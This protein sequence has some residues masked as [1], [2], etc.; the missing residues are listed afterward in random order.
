M[1]WGA[2]QI[3]QIKRFVSKRGFRE[4]DL[5]LEMVDHLACKMEELWVDQPH[6]TFEEVLNKAHLSFGV[7]GL[8]VIE[9][10]MYKAISLKFRRLAGGVGKKWFSFPIVLLLLG[11]SFLCY[12]FFYLIGPTIA[13]IVLMISQIIMLVWVF[14]VIFRQ[15]KGDSSFLI[16]KSI[17]PY[18]YFPFFILQFYYHFLQPFVLAASNP[19]IVPGLLVLILAFQ[20]YAL[21]VFWVVRHYANERKR[22]LESIYGI[23]SS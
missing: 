8:S 14:W 22:A 17:F 21:H 1:K 6:L 13:P 2:N 19:Y 5:Q 20:F 12:Q 18:S 4:I 15:S 7:M 11:F 23:F 16:T 10:N 3:D 9:D